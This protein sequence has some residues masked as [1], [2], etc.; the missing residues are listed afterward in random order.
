MMRTRGHSMRLTLL[1]LLLLSTS[2][3]AAP[4][5][6]NS[7][8]SW[9]SADETTIQ[10][11]LG[12]IKVIN[13][14]SGYEIDTALLGEIVDRHVTAEKFYKKLRLH[15]GPEKF[16]VGA[17]NASGFSLTNEETP[18]ATIGSTFSSPGTDR[19]T[20]VQPVGWASTWTL[21]SVNYYGGCP[22]VTTITGTAETF[23]TLSV[24]H[25]LLGHGVKRALYESKLATEECAA[26]TLER[27][28]FGELDRR[29]AFRKKS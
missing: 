6:Y 15:L 28:V 21:Y 27:I 9:T 29:V 26:A 22:G 2:S 12:P 10:T 16:V 7:I 13:A 18:D 19:V 11:H 5:V 17:K 1:A 24:I 4:P 3:C 8:P 14:K 20:C 25:E 23:L